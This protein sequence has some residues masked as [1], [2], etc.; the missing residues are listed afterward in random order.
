MS[1][2]PL[3]ALASFVNPSPESTLGTE[4]DLQDMIIMEII[5][6][7]ILIRI[8]RIMCR[9]LVTFQILFGLLSKGQSYSLKE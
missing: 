5:K 7:I 9:I 1:T 4:F 6:L 2:I 3:S 8:E